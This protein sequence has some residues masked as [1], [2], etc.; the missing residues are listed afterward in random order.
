MK[1]FKKH[2]NKMYESEDGNWVSFEDY[3]VEMSGALAQN[4]SMWRVN[5]ELHK[6]ILSTDILVGE[7][8]RKNLNL[9]KHIQDRDEMLIEKATVIINQCDQLIKKDV[10]ITKLNLTIANNIAIIWFGLVPTIIGLMIA[11]IMIGSK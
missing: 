8:T 2:W 9:E 6:N 10:N 1:K 11:I 5:E 7:L 4:E 3:D